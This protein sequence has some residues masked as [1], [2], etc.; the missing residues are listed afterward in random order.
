MRSRAR[1]SARRPRT[2]QPFMPTRRLP[3]G[4]AGI[5][6]EHLSPLAACGTCSETWCWADPGVT[7]C[8]TRCGGAREYIA[9]RVT[10]IEP[11]PSSLSQ[12]SLHYQLGIRAMNKLSNGTTS[13]RLWSSPSQQDRH[14]GRRTVLPPLLL[15]QN[16][17][18]RS[19]QW[20]Q[21]WTVCTVCGSRPGSDLVARWGNS[22]RAAH[23]SVRAPSATITPNRLMA[24][25]PSAPR[26]RGPLPGIST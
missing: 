9:E 19:L 14:H 1:P 26:H 17:A 20:M 10:G 21:S 3:C 8:D 13:Q 4:S 15:T 23:D 2:C 6:C 18:G 12:F 24:I 5:S 7:P 16:P 11:A 25:T 22:A